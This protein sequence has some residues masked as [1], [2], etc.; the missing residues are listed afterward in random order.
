LNI[1]VAEQPGGLGDELLA[2]RPGDTGDDGEARRQTIGPRRHV[3]LP[4]APHHRE[5][6]PHQKAIARVLGVSAFR[7]AIEPRHD[8]LV[9]AI[10]HVV[11]QA[12]IAA[13]EIERLQD[14]EVALILDITVR[15]ARG[16]VE[17]DDADIQRMCRIEF[18]E[19]DA[20]HPLIAP[21]GAECRA[22]EHRR[23]PFGNLDPLHPAACAHV[24]LPREPVIGGEPS[25]PI[26]RP[27]ECFPEERDYAFPRLAV[28]LYPNRVDR[29]SKS[30]TNRR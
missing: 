19:H 13:I 18:A 16:L 6:A 17:V 4:A 23:F 8:R 15:V 14:A 30:G 1:A 27:E 26:A 20:V 25:N 12:A 11:H 7:R 5:A 2:H 29:Y 28:F 22:T 3:A 24:V 21:H 9:A 10:G